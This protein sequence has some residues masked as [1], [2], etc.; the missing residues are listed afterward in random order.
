MVCFTINLFQARLAIKIEV[1]DNDQWNTYDHID[2]LRVNLTLD[3]VKSKTQ[4]VISSGR[5]RYLV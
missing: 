4:W 2:D 5:T 3:Q 1:L